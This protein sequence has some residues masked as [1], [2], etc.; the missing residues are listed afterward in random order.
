LALNL[1]EIGEELIQNKHK[2]H[3]KGEEKTSSR[4][5]KDM[6]KPWKRPGPDRENKGKKTGPYR[7]EIDRRLDE[8]QVKAKQKPRPDR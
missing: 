2:R 6:A 5:T 7:E 4:R 3:G 1:Q 8:G